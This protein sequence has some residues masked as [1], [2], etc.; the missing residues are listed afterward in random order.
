MSAGMDRFFKHLTREQVDANHWALWEAAE[1]V[2][3]IIAAW[4][5]E[6]QVT[7]LEKL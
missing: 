4:L 7:P 2:N 5:G 6:Q 3:N 1:E